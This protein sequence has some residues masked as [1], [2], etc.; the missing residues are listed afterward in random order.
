MAVSREAF[1]LRWIVLAV[2][3]ARRTTP[4]LVVVRSLAY[5][6]LWREGDLVFGFFGEGVAG[7]DGAGAV[8]GGGCLRR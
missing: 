8:G 3:G 1:G 4:A 5:F 6:L 2:P 7:G